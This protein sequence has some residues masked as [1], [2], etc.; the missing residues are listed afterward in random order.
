RTRAE[1]RVAARYRW[2]R[3]KV[4][5]WFAPALMALGAVL[6]AWAMYW[7]DSLVP[8]E[9][10]ASS[11]FVL[12]GTPGEMRSALLSMAGT[13]LAT[14]GVVFTLLTLPLSTVAAQ[15]GSRLLRL[16]LGDRTTQ[17]V[18]GM[19]VATF[20]YCIAA[21]LSIPPADVAPESPQLTASLGVYLMLATFATLILLVQHISTMLQA[22]NIAAAAGVELQNVVSAEISNE[23]TSGDEGSGRL[24]ARPNSQDAPNALAEIDGYPIR[25]RSTGYIQFVD[26]DTLLTLAREKDLIIRLLRRPGHYIWSGAVVALV[27]PAD[28]VDEQLDKLIRRAFQVGNGRTPTQDIEYAVNQLTEMAVRAMS[29][30]INDPFTAMTCLDHVGYGLMEF[31]RQGRKGSH[32]YDRDGKLRLVLEPVTLEVLL[33]AAFDMLRHA[34]CDNASV[35]LHMLK[36]ID[37]IG[38]EVKTPEARQQLLRH[39]SLIQA[40]SQAGALIEQDRQSIYRSG[41]ALQMK[42]AG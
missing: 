25:A 31:I 8:N 27:S 36:V 7:L 37:L 16:F 38:Q 29:P 6:L 5:F 41:E 12:S 22:P 28:R 17:F 9:A 15:Y 21:A 19:F 13:V 40:E 2:D 33:D 10:L 42:L 3:L 11:R 23:V 20:V 14:A 35:L 24:D 32:Y 26:P 34:S 30:A 4:S 1:R 39:V 18:L